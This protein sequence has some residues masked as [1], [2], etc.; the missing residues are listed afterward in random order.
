MVTCKYCS[1]PYYLK[2]EH[3]DTFFEFFCSEKCYNNALVERSI[4]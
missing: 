4:D 2:I 3:K 1:K